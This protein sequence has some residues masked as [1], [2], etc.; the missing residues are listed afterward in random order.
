MA[1]QEGRKEGR[2]AK[3]RSGRKAGRQEGK[4][5]GRK[6]GFVVVFIT[7]G[8]QTIPPAHHGKPID[9]SG[10]AAGGSLS[11]CPDVQVPHS[12]AFLEDGNNRKSST[13]YP[14]SV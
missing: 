8:W 3:R 1:S 9:P 7:L 12:S 5:E 4:E 13:P 10:H 14:R 6:A 2:K 11:A